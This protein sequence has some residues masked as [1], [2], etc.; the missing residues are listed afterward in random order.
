MN[1]SQKAITRG[2][3]KR[4]F[5]A[6][7]GGYIRAKLTP[8]IAAASCD[9]SVHAS[10]WFPGLSEFVAD[11]ESSTRK[12][13]GFAPKLKTAWTQIIIARATQMG[14]DVGKTVYDVP[15]KTASEITQRCG[16]LYHAHELDPATYFRRTR[17]RA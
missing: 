12:A 11:C 5:D 2:H 14:F 3:A 8:P 15:D 17:G 10:R 7:I 1:A 4:I 6:V 16:R 13:L 9:R